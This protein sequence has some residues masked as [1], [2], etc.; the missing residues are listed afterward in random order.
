[1][2]STNNC[3]NP[4][5]DAIIGSNILFFFTT[6]FY[7]RSTYESILSTLCFGVN[8]ILHKIVVLP[9]MNIR[10]SVYCKVPFPFY[11]FHML[12]DF[13]VAGYKMH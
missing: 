3:Q 6:N 1:M 13:L 8:A 10:F 11:S 5:G 2:P 7:R 4:Y 9:I 12:I